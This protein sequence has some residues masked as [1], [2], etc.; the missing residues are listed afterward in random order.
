VRAALHTGARYSELARLTVA[1]FHSDSGTIAIA[2]SKS[3]R[4]RFV[5]LTDEGIAF[6]RQLCV[7][8]AG[9]EIMLLKANGNPWKKAQAGRPMAAA[10]RR[11]QITPSIS[12]HT[13]RHSYASLSVMGG[14]PLHVLSKNLGH[15]DT[16]MVEKVYGHLEDGYVREAIR[17]GAPQFGAVQA[18][19]GNV[20]PLGKFT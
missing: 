12:F 18:D 3:G 16:R 17:N 10:V 8:R 2:R 9:H 13:L 20:L 6:F 1:D 14:V 4:S 7:G 15:V 5:H 19:K 11:A